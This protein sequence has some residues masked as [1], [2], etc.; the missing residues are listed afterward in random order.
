L[1][2]LRGRKRTLQINNMGER[3]K[4]TPL[5]RTEMVFFFRPKY[6]ESR[7]WEL[8]THKLSFSTSFWAI[9]VERVTKKAIKITIKRMEST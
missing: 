1:N 7:G 8:V 6:R 3:E 4:K 9:V 5:T 2:C